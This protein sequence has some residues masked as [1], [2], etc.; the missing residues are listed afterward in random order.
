MTELLMALD[1]FGVAAKDF[2]YD[3]K[4]LAGECR[5]ALRHLNERG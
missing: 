3:E 1:M 4:M 5:Y 2:G